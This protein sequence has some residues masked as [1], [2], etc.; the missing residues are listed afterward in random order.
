MSYKTCYQKKLFP[1][2]RN[3]ISDAVKKLCLFSK[4]TIQFNYLILYVVFFSSTA[5]AQTIRSSD[6]I[7]AI[8][9]KAEIENKIIETIT[10]TTEVPTDVQ[11]RVVVYPFDPRI[12][13]PHCPSGFNIKLP[14]QRPVQ[15]SNRIMVQCAKTAQDRSWKIYVNTRVDK[16]YPAMVAI[17]NINMGEKIDATN[18]TRQYIAERLL[19]GKHYHNLNEIQGAKVK[20]RLSKGQ[21]V[22]EP[23]VCYVCKGDM[24]SIE[25]LSHHFSLKTL[26]KAL[27]DGNVG[28]VIRIQNNRSRKVIYATVR[29]VG[30]VDIKL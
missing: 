18:V 19:R 13:V 27:N 16:M 17:R 20:R 28:E 2:A 10:A 5:Y 14:S 26:G 12:K 8:S 4:K 30:K 9:P 22:I 7:S 1:K 15:Q 11:L 24:V 29:D 3:W 6:S 21:Q 23:T 25:A